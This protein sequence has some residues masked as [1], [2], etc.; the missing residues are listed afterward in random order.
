MY[1]QSLI[2]GGNYFDVANSYAPTA[3][4]KVAL[5]GNRYRTETRMKARLV[6]FQHIKNPHERS[7][8][9]WCHQIKHPKASKFPIFRWGG[10][11]VK[12][13]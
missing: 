7:S 11:P 9:D 5:A 1:R 3:T 12:S 4:S 13:P 10:V 8:M 6:S 2:Y